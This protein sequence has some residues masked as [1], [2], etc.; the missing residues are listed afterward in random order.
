[1]LIDILSDKWK[2][3][4]LKNGDTVLL[5]SNCVRTVKY[6]L[7]KGYVVDPNSLLDS[8]LK[9]LGS[10]GTLLLPL[11]N[12]DFTTGVPFDLRNTPSHMGVLTEAGRLHPLAVR[13]GHPIYSFAA[14]GYRAEEFRNVNNFSGY[15]IDSPF[16][17]LREMDGKIAV[18]DLPDQN[19]MTFYHHIEEMNCVNY[20]YH[21]TFSGEYTDISGKTELRTYG[22]FVRK[23]EEGVITYLQSAE[24]LMWQNELYEGF[25]PNEGCGLRITSACRMFDFISDIIHSGNA[26]GTLYRIEGVDDTQ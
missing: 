13:T 10:S 16:G 20:R 9:V 12:F 25:K 4:G 8:F 18:L 14:I 23:L 2:K 3:A 24:N 6:A 17:I 22:L 15:G 21:K 11:F 5:H 19:S 1:M 7:Q 26:R